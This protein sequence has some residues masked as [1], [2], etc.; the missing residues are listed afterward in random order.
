MDAAGV[1]R[2]CCIHI[3]KQRPAE[4]SVSA[5]RYTPH[6]TGSLHPGYTPPLWSDVSAVLRHRIAPWS[7]PIIR[8]A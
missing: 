5:G 1:E 3:N 2:I 8:L 4:T 7:L 6:H